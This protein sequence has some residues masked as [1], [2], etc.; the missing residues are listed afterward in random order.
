MTKKT[1][2]DPP[3]LCCSRV[4]KRSGKVRSIVTKKADRNSL[5]M[6]SHHRSTKLGQ[7]T[8]GWGVSHPVKRSRSVTRISNY[9]T[10]HSYA[11]KY[12][13]VTSAALQNSVLCRRVRQMAVENMSIFIA[14]HTFPHGISTAN[15]TVC[16]GCKLRPRWTGLIHSNP[17]NSLYV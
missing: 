8:F 11:T 14:E 5:V 15:L 16:V 17:D 7:F 4:L 10:F 3:W 6:R 9:P 1:L 13:P 12:I 2:W